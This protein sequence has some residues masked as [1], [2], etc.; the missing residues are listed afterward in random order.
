MAAAGRKQKDTVGYFPHFVN[1]SK[2]KS[3]LKN[4]YGAEGYATWFQLLEILCKSK[5]HYFDCRDEWGY[6]WLISEIGIDKETFEDIAEFLARFEKIDSELWKHKIIW[7]QNL[8]DNLER[9]Y[10]KRVSE[11]PQKPQFS[12]RKLT[13]PAQKHENGNISGTEMQQSRVEQSTVKKSREKQR[14]FDSG[15]E[16]PEGDFLETPSNGKHPVDLPF[17]NTYSTLT[18]IFALHDISKKPTAKKNREKK[19]IELIDRFD[20]SFILEKVEHFNWCLKY[21]PE[22]LHDKPVS[23]LIKSIEDQYPPPAGYEEY[24]EQELKR[25]RVKETIEKSL[26]DSGEEKENDGFF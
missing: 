26:D 5:G 9:V 2:T 12:A 20:D 23:Y 13:N 1:D 24:R 18:D 15:D 14:K 25:K 21:R 22:L 6:E 17:K 8:V 10:Q 19:I 7:C 3:I 16:Q 11:I 4:K